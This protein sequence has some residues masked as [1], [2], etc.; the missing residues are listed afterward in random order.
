MGQKRKYW[1]WKGY[2]HLAMFFY[3]WTSSPLCRRCVEWKNYE[4]LLMTEDTVSVRDIMTNGKEQLGV[5][6]GC[7][8]NAAT[9]LFL[10]R[11]LHL[12]SSLV[13]YFIFCST[14]LIS[15]YLCFLWYFL[16]PLHRL[17]WSCC[18]D[19]NGTWVSRCS[20]GYPVLSISCGELVKPCCVRCSQRGD[21]QSDQAVR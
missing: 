15:L 16:F 11:C 3:F 5:N 19:V 17:S 9:S 10:T 1:A 4:V 6:M 21:Y 8:C 12:S 7:S 20:Y 2:V 14:L 13:F 18:E